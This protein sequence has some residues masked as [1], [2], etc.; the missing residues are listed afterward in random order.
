[1]AR[2]QT[3][4]NL[5]ALRKV[6]VP[7]NKVTVRVSDPETS[8]LYLKVGRAKSCFYLQKRIRGVEGNPITFFVANLEFVKDIS[9]VRREARRMA[10]LCDDGKDPREEKKTTKGLTLKKA[11][12]T[13]K[14]TRGETL[15]DSSMAVYGSQYKTHLKPLEKRDL[16]TFTPEVLVKLFIEAESQSTAQKALILFNNIWRVNKAVHLKNGKPLLGSSPY[17]AMKEIIG[18]AWN[19]IEKRDVA[20]ITFD[21]LGKYIAR[22]EFLAENTIW[23]GKK[24]HYNIFLLCLFTGLRFHEGATLS[25]SAVDF[26][27]G[28]I[29]VMRDYAKKK[30]EHIAFMCDYTRAL[31]QKMRLQSFS[32]WVFPQVDNPNEHTAKRTTLF[33]EIETDVLD[34]EFFTSHANR[35][36]FFCFAL[37]EC[38]IP[39]PTVQKMMSHK[40]KGNSVAERH[41]FLLDKFKPGKLKDEFEL[42]GRELIKLRDAWLAEHAH[43][44]RVPGEE[45]NV[46]ELAD[47]EAA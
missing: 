19:E 18:D 11:W 37:V 23:P 4:F 5:E 26:N 7:E 6:T 47:V 3:S 40:T 41:Y 24:V 25:W 32:P 8:G 15:R 43:T 34:G 29:K 20:I 46:V 13:F 31:L 45:N 30:R 44:L 9:T 22:L 14:K 39:F 16:A 10:A 27:K 33:R 28:T 35:R 12:E 17:D 2:K 1:M 21:D 38:K 42:V 36:S